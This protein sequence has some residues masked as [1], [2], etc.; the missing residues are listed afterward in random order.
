MHNWLAYDET[1][2]VDNI[3]TLTHVTIT[4]FYTRSLLLRS[5]IHNTRDTYCRP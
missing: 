1:I 4:L 2:A 5:M 3:K